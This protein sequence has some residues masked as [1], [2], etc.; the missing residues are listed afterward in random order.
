MT[1]APLLSD[2]MLACLHRRASYTAP[3]TMGRAAFR[4]FARAIGDDNPL[5]VDADYARSAGYRDVIAPLTLLCETNQYVDRRRDDDGYIGNSWDLP[6]DNCRQV[7]GG[8]SY[9]FFRPVYPDD[10]IQAD[11]EITAL[12]ERTTGSGL[13][14]LVVTSVATYTNQQGDLL[15]TNTETLIYI[16]DGEKD[17]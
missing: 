12:D 8:N 1:A 9:E 16:A 7:R 14:M 15:A 13:A 17:R 6:L 5:Y 3:E 11:W 10:V 2:E 4:Y